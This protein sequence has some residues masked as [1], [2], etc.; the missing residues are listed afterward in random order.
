MNSLTL[1]IIANLFNFALFVWVLVKFALPA[2]KKVLADRHEATM[3]AIGAAEQA[4]LQATQALEAT[5]AR[6]AGSEAE[7]ARLLEQAKQIAAAQATAIEETS[8]LEA[9][10]LKAAATAE[11][12]RERQAAVEA[13]R[14][15]TLQQAFERAKAELQQQMNPERQR[16]LVS[17]MIQKVGDGSLALK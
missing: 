10:R 8:R 3:A 11:I 5:Q 17:G 2:V 14:R 15:L 13:I 16:E 6:L 9:E 12:S 7:F 4:K 1:Q